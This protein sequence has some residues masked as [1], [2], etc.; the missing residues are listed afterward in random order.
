MKKILLITCLIALFSATHLS[1][2]KLDYSNL[3][4]VDDDRARLTDGTSISELASQVQCM[5]SDARELIDTLD[6]G[7]NILGTQGLKEVVEKVLT[8][9]PNLKILDL[10][11]DA[12][13]SDGLE[14]I[15]LILRRYPKLE[16]V[17]LS[18]N[19]VE[20]AIPEF[21]ENGDDKE[22]LRHQI[23]EKVIVYPVWLVTVK[24][25]QGPPNAIVKF[26]QWKQ[27]HNAF[28][29]LKDQ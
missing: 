10:S 19:G 21:L 5:D 26:P 13:D 29:A 20:D 6:L 25:L 14:D 4:I 3:D 23:I 15:F 7:T 18:G 8:L 12:I 1:A 22:G 16:Y 9:L 28:Y 11:F 2:N 27:T 24:T 17:N